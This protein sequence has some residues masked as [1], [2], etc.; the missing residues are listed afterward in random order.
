MENRIRMT[1]NKKIPGLPGILVVV[2]AHT[3]YFLIEKSLKFVRRHTGLD[4]VSTPLRRR[5]R[6]IR[7]RQL[8]DGGPQ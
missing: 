6:V 7:L 8:A 2:T 1:T 4:P 3:H 5:L